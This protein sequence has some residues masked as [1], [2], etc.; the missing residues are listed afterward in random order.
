MKLIGCI[1]LLIG[2]LGFVNPSVWAANAD[3]NSGSSSSNVRSANDRNIFRSEQQPAD[4]I[5]AGYGRDPKHERVDVNQQ[6]QQSADRDSAGYGRGL[7]QERA[8]RANYLKQQIQ[9]QKAAS[10]LRNQ[11][12]ANKDYRATN[13]LSQQTNQTRQS[14]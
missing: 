7:K 9:H 10:V 3:A 11:A 5:N 6:K 14:R 12:F 1:G 8:D 4:R 2:L 13:R